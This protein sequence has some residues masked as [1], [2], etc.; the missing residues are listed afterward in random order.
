MKLPLGPGQQY[1]LSGKEGLPSVLDSIPGQCTTY[2][3]LSIV[4][5]TKS[6]LQQLVVIIT[7]P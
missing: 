4:I 3:L 6:G 7:K 2:E 1:S 5:S